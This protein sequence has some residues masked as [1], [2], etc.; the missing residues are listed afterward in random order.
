MAKPLE[1]MKKNLVN[2][3]NNVG[4]DLKM[5]KYNPIFLKRI[6]LHSFLSFSFAHFT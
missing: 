5:N 6:L 1:N 2:V 4:Y 3:N